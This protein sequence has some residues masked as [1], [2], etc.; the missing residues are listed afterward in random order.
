[1]ELG[2]NHRHAR[3][4]Q[5]WAGTN[6]NL[7]VHTVYKTSYY[8]S[9]TVMIIADCYVMDYLCEVLYQ[10]W[11]LWH[12]CYRTDVTGT[13][14]IETDTSVLPA[15]GLAAGPVG[16]APRADATPAVTLALGRLDGPLDA[17]AVDAMLRGM[18]CCTTP[19]EHSGA[20]AQVP[21]S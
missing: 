21:R 13:C 14:S 18:S 19:R 8:V 16:P 4:E 20:G 15:E 12:L 3:G 6:L 7:C 2:P 11:H 1:M 9:Q 17:A 5:V 10:I